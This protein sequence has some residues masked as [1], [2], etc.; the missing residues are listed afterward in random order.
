VKTHTDDKNIQK[1]PPFLRSLQYGFN[2]GI[3]CV[4]LCYLPI[5]AQFS[6]LAPFASTSKTWILKVP[7]YLVWLAR[8]LLVSLLPLPLVEV[9]RRR[10]S[11]RGD[12]SKS[13]SLVTGGPFKILRHPEYFGEMSFL[14][15]LT[16][17][18]I[19]VFP[20]TPVTPACDLLVII[21]FNILARKEEQVNLAK[22][23]DAYKRYMKQVPRFNMVKGLWRLAIRASGN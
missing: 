5:F 10:K 9:Y 6:D 18:V 1:M 13:R 4:L 16:L 12:I 23:G 3:L 15:L 14:V 2:P 19:P 21:G 8:G 11:H 20:F 17:A 22:W 7:A